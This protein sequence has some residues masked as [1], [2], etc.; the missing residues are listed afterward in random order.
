MRHLLFPS[1]WT[2]N[3]AQEPASTT[4]VF[5]PEYHFSVNLP[6]AEEFI[7][8][9]PDDGSETLILRLVLLL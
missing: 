2:R 4:T 5:T 6:R 8:A 7:G 3:F 1:L 9:E